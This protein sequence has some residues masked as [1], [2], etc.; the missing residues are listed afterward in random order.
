[1]RE[2]SE[3]TVPVNRAQKIKF[4]YKK[5]EN[6]NSIHNYHTTNVIVEKYIVKPQEMN[7]FIKEDCPP[8]QD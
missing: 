7:I 4:V 5:E 1:M 6:D 2:R 8:Q 3:R